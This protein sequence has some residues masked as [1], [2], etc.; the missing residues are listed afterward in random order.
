MNNN[1]DDD[2]NDLLK[3]LNSGILL[4]F[5]KTANSLFSISPS[6]GKTPLPFKKK[7]NPWHHVTD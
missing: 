1:D 6:M 5:F 3:V 4:F 7:K 2:D